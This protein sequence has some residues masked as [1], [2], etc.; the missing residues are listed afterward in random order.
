MIFKVKNYIHPDRKI[1]A[2]INKGETP[3]TIKAT[4][5]NDRGISVSRNKYVIEASTFITYANTRTDSREDEHGIWFYNYTDNHYDLLNPKQCK[6]VLFTLICEG[7]KTWWNS[8]M[9]NSYYS[10]F[11]N[12]IDSFQNNGTEEG[13]LQFNNGIYIFEEQPARFVPPSSEYH[14]QFRLPY[15]Y[16]ENADCLNFKAFLND[17]FSGDQERIDL[18]QEIMGATLYY[19]KCMQNLIVFLGNGSNGKSLLANIIKY[20]LGANNVSSVPLDQLSGSQFARQNLDKKLLNVSSE[21][22]SGKIYST[23]DLKALTGGDSVEVEK[24]YQNSYTTEIYSKYI[25]LANEMIQTEDYSDGFYR[26]LIIIP[27]NEEYKKLV[28]GSEKIEGVKYQDVT[29]EADLKEELPGIFNFAY[30]GLMR[31]INQD[32]QLSFSSACE[33]ALERYKN[34]HNVVKAF[35]NDAVNV[36]GDYTDKVRSSDIFPAF[37]G[38]CR[39]NHYFKQSRSIT[40][41]KFFKMFEQA[42]GDMDLQITKKKHSD[43]YYYIGMILK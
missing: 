1:E 5:M 16:D 7:D 13:I 38:Y 14:C 43:S 35:L 28:P 32:Y 26:R 6:K 9:E 2:M 20:M 29:L 10:F 41:K 39:E 27:F 12:Q 33:K 37:E 21:V 17:I 36:S 15:D 18:I 3:D 23:A 24:K 25:L 8:A 22:N 40:K 4:Q 34:E 19:C 30:E 11:S 42:I 31:L